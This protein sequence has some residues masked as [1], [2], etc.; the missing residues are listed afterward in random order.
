MVEEVYRPHHAGNGPE[1]RIASRLKNSGAG[2]KPNHMAKHGDGPTRTHTNVH[3]AGHYVDP[4][5]AAQESDAQHQ[6]HHSAATTQD[7][8]AYKMGKDG[9][10]DD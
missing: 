4:S 2:A 3:S 7:L 6:R 1:A 9:I 5:T 10:E 8:T